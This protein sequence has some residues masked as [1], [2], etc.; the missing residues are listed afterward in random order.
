MATKD[1]SSYIADLVVKHT[2]EFKE[3]KELLIA[4]GIVGDS[5]EIVKNA[6]TI[7]EIT[8]ALTDLQASRFID[9]LIATKE[10]TRGS[11][12]SQKRIN[13][14]IKALDGIKATISDWDFNT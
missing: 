10:P 4:G 1:Q 7:H 11:E 9:M 13:T 3:V 5:A 12:Y 8:H 2:K 14:T 6:G